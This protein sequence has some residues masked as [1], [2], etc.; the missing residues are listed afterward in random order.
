[1]PGGQGSEASRKNSANGEIMR[2]AGAKCKT[3]VR[4]HAKRRQEGWREL[5]ALPEWTGLEL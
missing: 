5:Q 1:M 2:R 4:S 3:E